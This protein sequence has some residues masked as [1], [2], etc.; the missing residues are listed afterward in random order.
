MQVPLS[1]H[2]LR[3]H[4]SPLGSK[5]AWTNYPGDPHVRLACIAKFHDHAGFETLCSRMEAQWLGA[6]KLQI[7]LSALRETVI[8]L[9]K[10]PKIMTLSGLLL[11]LPRRQNDRASCHETILRTL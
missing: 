4:N 7:I 5:T 11:D 8:N 1:L 10:I 6:E 2:L 3:V 9:S